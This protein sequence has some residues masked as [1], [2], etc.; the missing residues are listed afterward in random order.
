MSD[1]IDAFFHGVDAERAGGFSLLPEGSLCQFFTLED[2]VF[3]PFFSRGFSVD[4]RYEFL[5]KEPELW[6]PL[7]ETGFLQVPPSNASRSGCGLWLF[8]DSVMQPSMVMLLELPP[9]FDASADFLRL[10]VLPDLRQLRR[11]LQELPPWLARMLPGILRR[12][13]P[14]LIVS[15]EGSGRQEILAFL[16]KYRFG[17]AA[18]R[19]RPGRIAEEVQLREFF[20]DAVGERLRSS[21]A[22]PVIARGGAIMIEEIANL[23]P[24]M[25]LRVLSALSESDRF[26]LFDTSRNLDAMAVAGQFDPALARLLSQNQS[27]LPPLRQQ[28]DLLAQEGQRY[29]SRLVAINMRHIQMTEAALKAIASYDWPGNLQEFYETIEAAYYLTRTEWIEPAD[30]RFGLWYRSEEGALNLRRRTE[31]LERKLLLQAH[32]IHGGNQVHMARALGISRG[33]LQYRWSR[34]GLQEGAR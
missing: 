19:F 20:G 12:P 34:L 32:A 15:E 11:D 25:Q 2:G 18:V 9:G 21:Q 1:L 33:S 29:L 22:T 30:L 3:R 14:L 7:F 8:L 26:W 6:A 5:A 24:A 23:A 28:R 16:Q 4:Y 17:G 13:S 27:I 10:L 31:E